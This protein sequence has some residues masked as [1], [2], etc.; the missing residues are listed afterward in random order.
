M[1]K[2]ESFA[3][4]FCGENGEY[5]Y[6]IV[7]SKTD[8]REMCKAL[9]GAFSGRGGGKPQIVQGSLSGTEENIKEFLK[10]YN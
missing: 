10:N 3:A 9:N 4:C 5:K 1:D 2:A 8:L 6:C 7:S